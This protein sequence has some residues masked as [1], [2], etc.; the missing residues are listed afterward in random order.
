[1]GLLSSWAVMALTHHIII[2]YCF[3]INNIPVSQRKYCVIGDDMGVDGELVASS[4]KKIITDLGMDISY[5]KSIEPNQDSKSAEIAKRIFI[6]GEEL[7]PI[8]PRQISLCTNSL[9]DLLSLERSLF[10]RSYYPLQDNTQSQDKERP[11]VLS[12]E[13]IFYA[14]L[15]KMKRKEKLSAYIFCSSPLFKKLTQFELA[16]TESPFSGLHSAIWSRVYGFDNQYEQFLLRTVSEKIVEYESLSKPSYSMGQTNKETYSPLVIKYF[17]TSIDEMTKIIRVYNT[18]YEDEEGDTDDLLDQTDPLTIINEILSRPKPTDKA[19]F[20]R[21]FDQKIKLS[22]SMLLKFL[23]SQ[24]TV[25]LRSL[26]SLK[27]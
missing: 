4:Y 1:M 13:L 17:K 21:R 27:L 18:S 22:E 20:Q 8:T 5:G 19:L 2:N 26:E 12:R 23:K 14:Y 25:N 9:N 10:D 11:G 3:E 24:R 6:D 15:K 16:K 7:S